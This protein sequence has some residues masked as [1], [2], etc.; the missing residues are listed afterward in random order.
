MT[1]NV[2]RIDE[3]IRTLLHVCL[4]C[5]FVVT[6][7]VVGILLPILLGYGLFNLFPGVRQLVDD[8]DRMVFGLHVGLSLVVI[9]LTSTLYRAIRKDYLLSL[10]FGTL[11]WLVT[12]LC[13]SL[14][15]V[16]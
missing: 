9:L 4:G 5:L 10:M 12:V 2:A 15:V 14:R 13:M 8:S 1:R 6:Y 16:M 11:T 3:S 7:Y